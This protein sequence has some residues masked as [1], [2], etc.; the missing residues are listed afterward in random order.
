MKNILLYLYVIIFLSS[1]MNPGGLSPPSEWKNTPSISE[2]PNQIGPM[3]ITVLN[4]GQG[5]STLITTPNGKNLLIDAGADGKGREVILPYLQAHQMTSLDVIIATHYHA[6]HIGGIDEV[7]AGRDGQL[8]SDDDFIP[9]IAVYDRGGT[10]FENTPIYPQYLNAVQDYRLSLTAGDLISIDPN[11]MI[12]CIVAGGSLLNGLSLDLTQEGISE[13]ENGSSVALLIEYG[14]FRYLTAGDLTGGGS[15]GGFKSLDLESPLAALIGEVSVVHV[16]HH[17]SLTSSNEVF[18]NTLRP[19]AA[20]FNVGDGNDYGQ[21]AQEVL[22]RWNGALAELW[23]TEKGS[24]GFIS[25]ENITNGPIEVETD[26]KSLIINGK[27]MGL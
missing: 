5:D 20:L 18:V 12:H 2:S 4:V 13:V 21:P 8:G 1:C 15:P 25:S 3:K 23:L 14:K 26:G 27:S 7:I 9:K 16:N 10:P 6:D 11:V 19:K 17:G 24:G 22:E